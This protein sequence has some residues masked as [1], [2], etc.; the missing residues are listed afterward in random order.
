PTRVINYVSFEEIFGRRSSFAEFVLSLQRYSRESLIYV[1]CLIGTL[2]ELWKRGGAKYELYDVFI[3]SAFEPMLA[4]C[5]C[6][7]RRINGTSSVFHRRQLLL[8][9]KTALLHGPEKGM[10]ALHDRPGFFG[11]VLLMA[12]DHFHY[13]LPSEDDHQLE[14]NVLTEF[15]A[16]NEFS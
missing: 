15:V 16:V 13:A 8:I 7:E 5:F 14:E 11:I 3:K 1:S 2:L 9:Q 4:A 10:D 6:H 12:N